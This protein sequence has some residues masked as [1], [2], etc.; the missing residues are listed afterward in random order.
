VT[1]ARFIAGIITERGLIEKPTK[2]K[3]AKLMK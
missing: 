2:A 1:P 3:I